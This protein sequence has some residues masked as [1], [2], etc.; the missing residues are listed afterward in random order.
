MIL[1]I[2]MI[3]AALDVPESYGV[4][5]GA[6]VR[7]VIL[8]DPSNARA[9]VPYLEHPSVRI[10]QNARRVL[11]LFGP[12]ATGYLAAALPQMELQGRRVGIEILWTLLCGQPA[13][14]VR[15]AILGAL[16]SFETLLDD[17]RLIIRNATELTD[18]GFDS[19][20][21]D[22]L[23]LTI[24]HLL[25]CSFDESIFRSSRVPDRDDQITKMRRQ[26]CDLTPPF[27]SV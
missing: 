4:G 11:C 24:R 8:T 21:C 1:D 20:V 5:N 27:V 25:S 7:A 2:E 10:A 12:A 13:S 18:R 6:I 26:L 9:L 15:D 16:Q 22:L 3:E 19:R 23:Y 17:R 14:I